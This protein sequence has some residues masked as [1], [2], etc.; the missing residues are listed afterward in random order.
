M[1]YTTDQAIALAREV[2]V[3]IRGHYDE[4]GATPEELTALCNKVRTQTLLEAAD[5]FDNTQWFD[6]DDAG[7]VAEKLRRM[8][9]E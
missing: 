8:A 1:T 4:S 9:G 2:G 6:L 5:T 7:I 3:A